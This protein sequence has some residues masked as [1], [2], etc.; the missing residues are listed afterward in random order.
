MLRLSFLMLLIC[1]GERGAGA[2][3]R[4]LRR[5][6]LLTSR[7]TLDSASAVRYRGAL[8]RIGGK[9]ASTCAHLVHDLAEGDAVAQVGQRLARARHAVKRAQL[10][11]DMRK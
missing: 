8:R 1:G 7:E 9:I 4:A 3:W 5:A 11:D 10:E 6:L 2:N